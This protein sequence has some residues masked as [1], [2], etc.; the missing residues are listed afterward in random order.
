MAE[1]ECEY[2]LTRLDREWQE[3]VRTG[4]HRQEF[5]SWQEQSPQLRRVEDLGSLVEQVDVLPLDESSELVWA[6]LDLVEESDLAKRALLQVIVPGLGGELAWINQWASRVDAGLL[7]GGDI[8]QMI[9]VSALEAIAHAAGHHR[10]WP[11]SSILRRT[12][13]LL[14][15]EVRA[16]EEWHDRVELASLME[17]AVAKGDQVETRPAITLLELFGEATKSGMLAERDA[18]LLWLMGV[19]GYT[20]KEL[21]KSLGITP[22]GVATRR[23][24]AEKRLM[25]MMSAA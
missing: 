1:Y 4:E 5:E 24:R 21:A 20:S 22:R 14:V 10:R 16:P 15:R 18:R 19:E 6:L 12:H 3:I 23:L 11:I 9:I 17:E 7:P 8:D 13:R 25:Q 2:V